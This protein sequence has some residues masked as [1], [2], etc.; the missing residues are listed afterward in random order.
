MKLIRNLIGFVMLLLIVV[1]CSNHSAPLAKGEMM[2]WQV[3]DDDSS[4]YLLG[5]MHFGRADFYPLPEV[6]EQAYQKSEVVGVELDMLNVDPS[7]MQ[8]LI[9]P[10]MAY[11]DG[12][13]LKDH[14]SEETMHLTELYFANKG[15]SLADLGGMKAGMITMTIS[16]IEAQ[17]AGL[18]PQYG[19]D[20]HFLTKA[21]EDGKEI[22][23]FET[24]E[25]QLELLFSGD[26]ESAEGLLYKTLKEASEFETM[27]DSMATI[28]K[29]GDAE[30]M[31][32]MLTAYETEEEK[33]YIENLF[34]GRDVEM[35]AKI[36]ELLAQ[37]KAAF[38][39]LGAGHFVNDDGVINRL[40][41]NKK[42]K[43]IKY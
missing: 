4:V 8:A 38:V 27:L 41:K 9:M 42:Y 11:N 32:S 23:E 36:Q 43:I 40:L 13:T 30:A 34:T 1:G 17:I 20:M 35:T 24:M 15:I 19:I 18:L 39:I 33:A 25:S 7:A 2:F 16:Q 21:K 6:I 14:V 3:S 5:S 28:W 10:N 12:T 29:A 31:N 26:E 22:M 37:N